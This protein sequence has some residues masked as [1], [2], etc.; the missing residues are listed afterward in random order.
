MLL[1]NMYFTC[2]MQ[3]LFVGC[4][5]RLFL[6]LAYRRLKLGDNFVFTNLSHTHVLYKWNRRNNFI[7]KLETT[8]DHIFFIK[9]NVWE[10]CQKFHNYVISF[11]FY[12]VVKPTFACFKNIYNFLKI[13]KLISGKFRI[14]SKIQRLEMS[15]VFCSVICRYLIIHFWGGGIRNSYVKIC[16][17]RVF[18]ANITELKAWK[19]L[20][21]S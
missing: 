3:Q 12:N 19:T 7:Q 13:I 20:F 16:S 14:V 8:E 6:P 21:L 17:Y 2:S 1:Y 11:Q 15:P 9:F 10:W 5:I 4:N 18:V